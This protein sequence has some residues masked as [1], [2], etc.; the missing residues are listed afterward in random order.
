MKETKTQIIERQ[1][2]AGGGKKCQLQ[3]LWLVDLNMVQ[4]WVTLVAE[5]ELNAVIQWIVIF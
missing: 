1:P 2:L 3:L 4:K 5:I